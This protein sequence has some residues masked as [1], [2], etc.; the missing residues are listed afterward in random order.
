MKLHRGLS[1]TLTTHSARILFIHSVSVHSFRQI[2]SD[3]GGA[4]RVSGPSFAVSDARCQV[5]VGRDDYGLEQVP[6]DVAEAAR[7]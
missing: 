4:R 5:I 3:A 2:K 7:V 6:L 1:V